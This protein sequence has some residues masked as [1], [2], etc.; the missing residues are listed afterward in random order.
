MLSIGKLGAG[1]QSYYLESVSNGVEDYYSGRGEAPGRWVG[2][3]APVIGLDGRVNADNLRAVLEGVDPAS[4]IALGRA[5][6]DRV[7]GFDL[8]FRAPKSVSVLF[9]LGGFEVSAEV[10]A[11]HEASVDA[12]LGYLERE[13]C[14]SRRGTNG[15]ESIIGEGFVA[16]AFRHRSSRAGDPHLHT[17]VL[18]ANTTRAADGR[19]ATLDAR[20]IYLHAKTAGYMYE[21][22]LRAELTR[23]LG[24]A[25]RPVINGIADL[26]GIPDPVL[27][28]FSTRRAEIEAEMATRGV[29]SAR[30]AEIAALDTRQAK[31]YTVDPLT[32]TERW[33]KRAGD[34]DVDH[35]T[36]AATMH[37]AEPALLSEN[38][39]RRTVGDLLGPEGL[40]ERA[41]SFDRRAV[42]RAWCE[43]LRAGAE[44][45]AIEVLADCTL[46]E[47]EVV[48]LE[49]YAPTSLQTRAGGRRIDGPDLG[50]CYS[51]I[52]LLA[53]EQRLV[54]NAVDRRDDSAGVVADDV[55]LAALAARL[56]ISDEQAAM[57][58]QLTT[59]GR[60]VD[61]V[62]A[63]AGTG[64]TFALDAARDAWQRQGNHVIGAALAARAAAE[65]E[66]TAGIRSDTIASLLADLDREHGGLPARTVL[67]IDEAGMVGTRTLGRLLDHA[68]RAHAKVVLVGDPRQLPEI[69][70]GGLLR[71]IGTRLE[72]IRLA[73]NRR[74]HEPWER[75]ALGALRTGDIDRALA[76]YDEHER[77][78]THPTASQT[79]EAM[80]ADWWAASLRHDRVLMV[81]ARWSDV[82]DLN[83]RARQRV[84][85]GGELSGP[86]LEI[87]GRPY[88]A[89]DR[90]VTLRNQRALGV[91]NGTLATITD[92]D[93]DARAVTIRTDNATSHVLPAGYLDA[94]HLRHAY[95]TTIHKAQGVTVD[96][97]LVLG[98]DALYQEAAY[99][100]LSRGRANNRVY[101]VDNRD[102]N[103]QHTPT[104]RR[105]P[106]DSFAASLHVTRAQHLAIDHQRPTPNPRRTL[107]QRYHELERLRHLDRTTP[108]NPDADIAALQRS[109]TN[110]QEELDEQRARLADLTAKRP[111]RHRREHASQRLVTAQR[112]QRLAGKLEQTDRALA[113]THAPRAAYDTFQTRHRADLEQLPRIEREVQTLLGQHVFDYRTNPPAYLSTLGPWPTD[114]KPRDKWIEAAIFIEEYRHR[115]HITDPQRPFGA[116]D[117]T[118]DEQHFAQARVDQALRHIAPERYP[119]RGAEIEL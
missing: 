57:V 83:A 27:R 97:V 39:Q 4:G 80:A 70:A 9:G 115:E 48:A 92:V 75:A 90:V 67:V 103:E 14:W 45:T 55:A 42:L 89:G 108:R 7:P 54:D 82:D 19:W 111:L 71:G 91:R 41:S 47:P 2:A 101:L 12:A 110:I 106:L 24:V 88:Q 53:L 85:S 84:A 30:A 64:K 28:A 6:S 68:E 109:R 31:D 69:E 65:L 29:T 98:N 49:G 40:T 56:E 73:Q 78:V 38:E 15:T 119:Q 99:V 63:A 10:H 72:P 16:A 102:D 81:A 74:Q 114:G 18:V 23:R 76:A 79:R 95:A 43:H 21:A 50:T 37:R 116:L 34:L 20:R 51:T 5:R 100:A 58:L 118:N 52:E 32:M 1:Q 93:V 36:I 35:D 3:G 112:V 104:P 62:I 77:I 113:D 33:W 46:A 13:A 105:E 61:V 26:E 60:G 66:T 25:W 22:N 96:Q 94:G 86:E 17:H 59:G 11:A 8:T 117:R 87:D 44:V 107:A